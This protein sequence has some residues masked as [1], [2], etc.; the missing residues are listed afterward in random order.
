MTISPEAKSEAVSC[1]NEAESASGSARPEIAAKHALRGLELTTG[2]STRDELSLVVRLR[3]AYSVV[4]SKRTGYEAAKAV[5]DEAFAVASSI[6]DSELIALCR[7]QEVCLL[8]LSEEKGSAIALFQQNR[9]VFRAL[10]PAA[11]ARLHLSLGNAALLIDH[12]VDACASFHTAASYGRHAG[13]PELTAMAT[14]NIGYAQYLMGDIPQAFDRMQEALNSAIADPTVGYLDHA[15]AMMEAGTFRTAHKYM[16]SALDTARSFQHSALRGH[17][18]A[19]LCRLSILLGE[20]PSALEYAEE[21]VAAWERHGSA[22]QLR[23]ARL[24]HWYSGTLLSRPTTENTRVLTDVYEE[25]IADADHEM[26]N[27]AQLHRADYATSSRS[28]SSS[29]LDIAVEALNTAHGARD[30]MHLTT[31]LW[32]HRLSAEVG[33]LLLDAHPGASSSPQRP[34]GSDGVREHLDTALDD[35]RSSTTRLTAIDRQI[36]LS[37]HG[38]E[39]LKLAVE[40]AWRHGDER[41]AALA[42]RSW[43]HE[44]QRPALMAPG[45]DVERR[46]LIAAAR[47]SIDGVWKSTSAKRADRHIKRFRKA[48][49]ELQQKALPHAELS[50]MPA[51]TGQTCTFFERGAEMLSITESP[52]SSAYVTKVADKASILECLETVA[53]DVAAYVALQP[54][55]P[56]GE[57]QAATDSTI[58]DIMEVSLEKSTS[59]LQD[60]LGFSGNPSPEPLTIAAPPWMSTIPWAMLPA[61]RGRPVVVRRGNEPTTERRTHWQGDLRLYVARDHRLERA[62]DEIARISDV[63]S[64]IAQVD[65]QYKPVARD[66]TRRI[67]HCDLAHIVVER[68]PHLDNPQFSTLHLHDDV[69][70][71]TDL[72]TVTRRGGLVV[73]SGTTETPAGGSSQGQSAN[74]HD[75]LGFGMA[76]LESGAGAV[77][78]AGMPMPSWGTADLYVMFHRLLASSFTSAE[79]DSTPIGS[80]ASALAR[81][82]TLLPLPLR[83]ANLYGHDWPHR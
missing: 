52:E 9:Y 27:K 26:A 2:A 5:L 36:A 56:H 50:V 81:A 14:H 62:S 16:V 17:A 38:K 1:L 6:Q 73:L 49:A 31:R 20:G 78:M 77:V 67:A 19:E 41:D 11:S 80:A 51:A 63:W 8:A 43:Q 65:A 47:Q 35:L 18:S 61:L 3:V 40:T 53:G 24:L 74:M 33:L 46:P 75:P 23:R 28:L 55:A 54:T 34:S 59:R 4:L 48:V 72:R 79:S 25:A 39:L 60:L 69:V 21:S 58:R 70:I 32:F 71:G 82:Q 22:W 66:I 15:L 12:P 13:N 42:A 29:D 83:S 7:A 44:L 10:S 68:T 76:L 45:N 37:I 57:T 30:S 64:R